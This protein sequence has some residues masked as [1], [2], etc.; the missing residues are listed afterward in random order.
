MMIRIVPE[1]TYHP[2]Q[3]HPLVPTR[4]FI[5]I[6]QCTGQSS[7]KVYAGDTR[8]RIYSGSTNGDKIVS[9]YF[10]GVYAVI[11]GHHRV[12]VFGPSNPNKPEK[13]WRQIKTYSV[14]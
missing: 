8:R 9:Y 13:N 6:S 10:D 1:K 3:K 11:T 2:K 4:D 7:F 14:N 12:F 5:T